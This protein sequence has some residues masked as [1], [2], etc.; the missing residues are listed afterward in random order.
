MLNNCVNIQTNKIIRNWEFLR[1]ILV[2]M[3][4]KSN[5]KRQKK[6]ED[7]NKKKRSFLE[8]AKKDGVSEKLLDRADK[9]EN[10][11]KISFKKKP[12]KEKASQIIIEFAE[13]LLELT[14]NDDEIRAVI[15]FAVVAWNIAILPANIRDKEYKYALNLFKYNSQQI[16]ELDK[17]IKRKELL[18]NQYNFLI[19]DYEIDFTIEG[20]LNLSVMVAIKED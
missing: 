9:I 14:K 10:T 12:F 17:L 8:K 6:K 2:Y 7:F 5:I 11:G 16:T 18:F 20:E 4:I 19:Q 1:Y 3:S 15:E 13:P